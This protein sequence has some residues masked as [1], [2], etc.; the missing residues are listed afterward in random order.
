MSIDALIEELRNQNYP[1]NIELVPINF[2]RPNLL[3]MTME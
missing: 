2:P 1:F 3:K